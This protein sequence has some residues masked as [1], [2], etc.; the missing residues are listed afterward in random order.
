MWGFG[1]GESLAHKVLKQAVAD[2]AAGH[3]RVASAVVEDTSFRLGRP[4]VHISTGEGTDYLWEVQVSPQGDRETFERTCEAYVYWQAAKGTDFRTVPPFTEAEL[5]RNGHTPASLETALRERMRASLDRDPGA[6][7][8]WTLEWDFST[9]P[10]RIKE[11]ASRMRVVWVFP[12][13]DPA[14][15]PTRLLGEPDVRMLCV[16]ATW[17]VDG[18][19]AWTAVSKDEAAMEAWAAKAAPAVAGLATAGLDGGLLLSKAKEVEVDAWVCPVLVPTPGLA[20]FRTPGVGGHLSL[21]GVWMVPKEGTDPRA[22]AEFL[23]I[24]ECLPHKDRVNAA[25]LAATELGKAVCPEMAG[26]GAGQI[27][28]ALPKLREDGTQEPAWPLR[29]H[30]S[31]RPSEW[32]VWCDAASRRFPVVEAD[33]IAPE[34]ARVR[35]HGEVPALAD[36]KVAMRLPAMLK[37]VGEDG[38]VRFLGLPP[39]E[40]P[41]ASRNAGAF[42]RSLAAAKAIQDAY[43]ATSRYSEAVAKVRPRFR[44]ELVAAAPPRCEGWREA[45]AAASRSAGR[46]RGGLGH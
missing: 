8:R 23:R 37:L 36:T 4:D 42:V 26:R 11:L 32:D 13:A 1:M 41:A 21:S 25:L 33:P 17:L 10:G 28:R 45:A 40:G 27:M 14:R 22:R 6:A 39:R 3:G 30:F 31:L 5:E 35:D 16:A 20:A 29:Q 12:D 9:P 46:D 19:P 15:T 43:A 7:D 34:L 44:D 18:L 24:D 38:S 2:A